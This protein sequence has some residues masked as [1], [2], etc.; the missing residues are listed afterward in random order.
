[1]SA[2]SISGLKR[3]SMRRKAMNS[4]NS[5]GHSGRG[6]SVT[7]AFLVARGNKDQ[8]VGVLC[9][10]KTMQ[11]RNSHSVFSSSATWHKGK[12]PTLGLRHAGSRWNCGFRPCLRITA[13]SST[14]DL[15]F[16]R[17]SRLLQRSHCSTKFFAL[18]DHAGATEVVLGSGVFPNVA[19]STL[20][21]GL[22]MPLYQLFKTMAYGDTCRERTCIL[23][24]LFHSNP[25]LRPR[26]MSSQRRPQKIV[27]ALWQPVRRPILLL[28]CVPRTAMKKD[29]KTGW[30][31]W[32]KYHIGTGLQIFTHFSA[33]T[34]DERHRSKWSLIRL[35][36]QG[37]ISGSTSSLF[38][39]DALL[40]CR[41]QDLGAW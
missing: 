4:R 13:T 19:G 5:A 36:A 40:G 25:R 9:V 28:G 10:Q 2:Q 22:Q 8:E 27:L 24:V 3:A 35:L 26:K 41:V 12:M 15:A 6:F 17:P 34:S 14:F 7:K 11:L 32:H 18:C 20:A 31:K 23:P 30:H 39:Q 29:T 21:W 16:G 33:F 1:M 38:D 37:T